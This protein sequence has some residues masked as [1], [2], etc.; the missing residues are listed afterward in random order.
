MSH[1]VTV[2]VNG[3]TFTRTVEPRRPLADFLREDLEL[4]GTHVGCEHGIC[5][6]CTVLMN[7][8]TVRSC[9]TFAVQAD[10]AD[11]VTVEGLGD[12][13]RPGVVQEAFWQ[14][15]GLQC[16]FCTPGML[17]TA[18]ELLRDNPSPT[19]AEVRE[20]IAGVLCRCTGYHHIIQSVLAAAA[21]LR[22]RTP[23]SGAAR[24]A[25]ASD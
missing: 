7:G 5:G 8:E 18:T 15:H 24:P 11:L 13:G 6:A 17:M 9:L 20:G 25:P 1:S 16:G 10:G 14:H 2:K 3:R 19:E 22:E 4:T 21:R 12:G 23:T